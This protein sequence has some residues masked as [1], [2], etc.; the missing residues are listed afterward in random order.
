[1]LKPEFFGQ[2]RAYYRNVLKA[3]NEAKLL[4]TE[5]PITTAETEGQ[6]QNKL[7]II[8]I[9]EIFTF[10]QLVNIFGDV[11]YSEAIDFENITPV[12]D[13][14][15]GIY[16]DLFTRLNAVIAGLNVNEASFVGAD[17]IY[18]PYPRLCKI[19]L[20]TCVHPGPG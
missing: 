5:D 17:Q 20:H 7:Y 19:P 12:Y 10:H 4:I 18:Q 1:M 11:P 2:Y 14:A 3:L 15:A 8:E 16:A 6:K 9:L 13:D